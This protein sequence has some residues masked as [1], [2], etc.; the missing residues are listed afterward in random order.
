MLLLPGLVLLVLGVDVL[1]AKRKHSMQK[2]FAHSICH[3]P[4][5][6][7]YLVLNA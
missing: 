1:L 7:V 3:D 5:D 2:L 4:V 6:I